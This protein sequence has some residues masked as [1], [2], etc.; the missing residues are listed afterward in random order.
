MPRIKHE[1]TV[2]IATCVVAP[3]LA[4]FIVFYP[5]LSDWLII[6]VA[7]LAPVVSLL[8]VQATCAATLLQCILI[9]IGGVGGV[10]LGWVW[11]LFQVNII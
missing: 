2:A 6:Q 5:P 3:I 10:I 4:S 8:C 11:L 9:L 1:S 7:C